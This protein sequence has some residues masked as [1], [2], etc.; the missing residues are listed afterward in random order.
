MPN[1]YD[2]DCP[3][4][5]V[6]CFYSAFGCP[7]KVSLLSVPSELQTFCVI[8]SIAFVMCFPVLVSFTSPKSLVICGCGVFI[9]RCLN[10]ETVHVDILHFKIAF[11]NLKS[12]VN[13]LLDDLA[14]IISCFLSFHVNKVASGISSKVVAKYAYNSQSSMKKISFIKF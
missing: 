7:E 1:H 5:P 3:T 11:L 14:F 2:N 12:S 9:L 6:P 13:N 10:S 4:A 8:L